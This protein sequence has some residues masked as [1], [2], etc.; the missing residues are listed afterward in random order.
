MLVAHR[1]AETREIV[2]TALEGAGFTTV[3]SSAGEGVIERIEGTG[4][5]LAILDARLALAH[6]QRILD[7]LRIE[8]VPIVCIAPPSGTADTADVLERGA[9]D[10]LRTPF[11]P[12]ELV[13]RVKAVLRGYERARAPSEL[14][15]LGPI[16]VD[17][18]RRVVMVKKQR[19]DLTRSELELLERLVASPGRVFKRDELLGTILAAGKRTTPRLIDTHM[20]SL[21]KKLGAAGSWIETIR[22]YGYRARSEGS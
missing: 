4:V 22:G 9:D 14:L 8:G 1:D 3:I 11:S 6:T 19:V 18:G 16:V 20:V 7:W 15:R 2:R 17:R 13:A 5:A 10:V 12:R 21:R